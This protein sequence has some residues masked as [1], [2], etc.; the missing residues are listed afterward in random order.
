MKKHFT[1]IELL[2]V[3]AIIAILAG[4]LLPALNNAREK[5]R[6]ASCQNNLKQ[7]GLYFLS[8]CDNND[9]FLPYAYTSDETKYWFHQIGEYMSPKLAYT[10]KK[11]K[12]P[13]LNCPSSKAV[14]QSDQQLNY[15]VNYQITQAA[16][17][18]AIPE[19]A[20][21]KR[22]KIA[23]SSDITMVA[24]GKVY[25]GGGTHYFFSHPNSGNGAHHPGF[26]IHTKRANI[27]WVDGHV[28]AVQHGGIGN[29]QVYPIW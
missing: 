16:D 22:T 12:A 21:V 27:L 5:S 9:D 8:Y 19:K 1:L 3:I 25:D 14:Y 26:D 10:F 11:D 20:G 13:L 23:K 29:R 15:V 4:M 7:V 18:G 24:D 17:Q 28:N 6:A 2:V